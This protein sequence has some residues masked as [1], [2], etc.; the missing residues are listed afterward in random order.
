MM[1]RLG[2]DPRFAIRQLRRNRGYSGV[3][4]ITLALA[5]WRQYRDLQRSLYG[6]PASLAVSGDNRSLGTGPRTRRAPI[7]TMDEHRRD[8]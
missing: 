1:I 5:I 7:R 6:Y 2:Q 8:V 3:A 4:T